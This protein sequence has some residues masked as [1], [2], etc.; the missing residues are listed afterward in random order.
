[1]PGETFADVL[2]VGGGLIGCM[3]ARELARDGLGV[4]VVERGALGSGASQD[5]AGMLA[6]QAEVEEG[7]PFLDLC[8]ESS[9]LYRA[10][11]DELYREVGADIRYREDGSL[12]VAF[13]EAEASHLRQSAE[14]QERLGLKAQMI[15]PAA[16]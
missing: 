9:R 12:L 15:D 13:D 10:L 1:M 2:V 11:A 14:L 16:A 5:A 3:I 4:G 6:P 8:L 7:G